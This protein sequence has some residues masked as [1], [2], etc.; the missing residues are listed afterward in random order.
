[1]DTDPFT[2]LV[3]EI[4]KVLEGSKAVKLAMGNARKNI[5]AYNKMRGTEN[6]DVTA[7]S[8]VP[9]I[10]IEASGGP[11]NINLASNLASFDMG[12]TLFI[13]SGDQRVNQVMLPVLWSIWAT[14]A[15]GINNSTILSLTWQN[16]PFVKK[17][18]FQNVAVG[19]SNPDL[20]RGIKGW[21]AICS[22]M[23]H[24]M[25]QKSDLTTFVQA[26]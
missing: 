26:V 17:Y 2:L 23:F 14:L 10:L 22:L 18:E 13:N 21:T 16:R 6:L 5:R 12:F 8:D 7:E 3:N 24:M 9:E 25:F 15:D 4:A 11:T 20:N 1:M 19:K